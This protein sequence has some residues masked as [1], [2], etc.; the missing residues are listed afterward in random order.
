MR[1]SD[2]YNVQ[3]VYVFPVLKIWSDTRLV[4]S[5]PRLTNLEKSKIILD[6]FL[7]QDWIP[8]FEPFLEKFHNEE[9]DDFK[10]RLNEAQQQCDEYNRIFDAYYKRIQLQ[11]QLIGLE[12]QIAELPEPAP[13]NLFTSDFDYRLDL[14]N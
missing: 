14:N 10:E 12:S 9:D 1:S 4:P 3:E 5:N 6:F 11:K 8:N 2:I 13:V 7:E